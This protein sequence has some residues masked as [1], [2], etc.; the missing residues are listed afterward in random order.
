MWL[1][2][3]NIFRWWGKCG[4]GIWRTYPPVWL[5]LHNYF[6]YTIF[7]SFYMEF[8]NFFLP[9][10]SEMFWSTLQFE[11]I[12]RFSFF[13][14]TDLHNFLTP[15]NKIFFFYVKVNKMFLMSHID[16]AECTINFKNLRLTIFFKSRN[17]TLKKWITQFFLFNSLKKFPKYAAVD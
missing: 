16:E 8:A 15:V 2:F 7:L 6:I 12:L 13:D 4:Q 11:N 9:I 17:L 5:H 14:S 10:I 3:P 1:H